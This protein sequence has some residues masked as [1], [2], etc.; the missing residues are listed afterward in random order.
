MSI[1]YNK[2]MLVGEITDINVRET[3][4]AMI[5]VK[6]SD[7]AESS[8]EGTPVPTS[9]TPIIAMRVPA[10]IIK[11][12]DNS[13]LK[14]KNKIIV[15]GRLQGVKRTVEGKDFYIVEAQA[16]KIFLGEEAAKEESE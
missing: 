14:I 11:D 6:A 1:N 5:W 2:F 15:E 13:V 3:G 8:V 9:F 10:Y 16:S 4:A 12:L 7:R